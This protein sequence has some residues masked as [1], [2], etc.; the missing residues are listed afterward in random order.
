MY[1]NYDI[2]VSLFCWINS[3]SQNDVLWSDTVIFLVCK[4]FTIKVAVWWDTL[5]G[6]T[7]KAEKCTII[8]E[9]FIFSYHKM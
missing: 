8:F 9:N 5:D 6:C 2:I 7:L 3:F 1:S 4:V